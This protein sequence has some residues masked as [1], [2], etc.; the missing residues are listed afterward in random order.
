MDKHMNKHK[1]TDKEKDYITNN[2]MKYTISEIAENLG[3]RYASVVYFLNVNNIPHLSCK[4]KY[5]ESKLSPREFEVLK[6][7]AKGYSNKEIA[8]ELFLSITTIKT[9]I[10][11]IYGKLLLT[12]DN[13][14]HSEIRVKAVLMYLDQGEG[15]L[16]EIRKC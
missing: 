12:G 14:G 4:S 16:N 7:M 9:H 1:F 10:T 11:N 13:C 8:D 3:M 5:Y 15:L 6:L 2:A